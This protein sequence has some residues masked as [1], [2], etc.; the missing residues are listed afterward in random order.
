MTDHKYLGID[1]FGTIF[2]TRKNWEK[3]SVKTANTYMWAC[4]KLSKEGPDRVNW[5]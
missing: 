1:T 3:R 4:C 2:K 5:E